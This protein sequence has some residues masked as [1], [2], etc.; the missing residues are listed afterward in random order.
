[1]IAVDTSISVYA[2]RE[3]TSKHELA[4]TWLFHLAEGTVPWALPV[5]C[6]GEYIRVI[7]RRNVFDPP[8][9]LQ[10][11]VEGIEF[12]LQSPTIRLLNPAARFF[13]HLKDMLLESENT[14]NL[15]FDAQIAAL[16]R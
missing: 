9:S 10:D 13:H 6:I 4:K 1:V 2:H 3:E 11:A 8:S 5:F 15:T 7:T 14:G 16:C 12:L